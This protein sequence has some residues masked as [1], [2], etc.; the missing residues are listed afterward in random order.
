MLDAY[1][2]ARQNNKWLCIVGMAMGPVTQCELGFV[3]KIDPVT[4]WRQY[5]GRTLK[6]IGNHVPEMMGDIA[7]VKSPDD[8]RKAII[9][10]S[11]EFEIR[12]P[13]PGEYGR[14][15]NWYKMSAK[16]YKGYAYLK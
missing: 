10:W 2:A 1:Y 15:D 3:V 11:T 4:H 13:F 8:V 9:R 6:S 14:G 12:G 7:A 5:A 16:D